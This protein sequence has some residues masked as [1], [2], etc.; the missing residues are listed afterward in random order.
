M[1][2]RAKHNPRAL[3]SNFVARLASPKTAVSNYLVI[4]AVLGPVEHIV[5][6]SAEQTLDCT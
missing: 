4:L 5:E 6:T 3:E 2:S 1:V